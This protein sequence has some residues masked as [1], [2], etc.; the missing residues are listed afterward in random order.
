MI[1][2]KIIKNNNEYI[3]EIKG[4]GGLGLSGKDIL[5]SSVSTAV[6]MTLNLL[7]KISGYNIEKNSLLADGYTKIVYN[8]SDINGYK[9]LEVLEFT[10]ND[11]EKQFPKNIKRIN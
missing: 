2:Y 7:E 3:F 4:H 8:L 5:C 1:N 10:L 11:L 6:Y 9:I